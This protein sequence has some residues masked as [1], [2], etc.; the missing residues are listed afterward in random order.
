MNLVVRLGQRSAAKVHQLS[1]ILAYASLL[2]AFFNA[3]PPKALISLG[4]LPAGIWAIRRAAKYFGSPAEFM[5]SIQGTVVVYTVMLMFIS[6][7]LVVVGRQALSS[8]SSGSNSA[9]M[10]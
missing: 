10:L 9:S 5:K 2:V 4:T 6:F 3:L 8:T 7:A 1:I